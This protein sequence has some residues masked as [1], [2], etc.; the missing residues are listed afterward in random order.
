MR[1]LA[2][3]TV[4]DGVAILTYEP[5][6]KDQRLVNILTRRSPLPFMSNRANVVAVAV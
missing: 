1:L 2:N 6:R 3:K 4:G 5:I